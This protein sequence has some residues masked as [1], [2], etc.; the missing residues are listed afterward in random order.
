MFYQATIFFFFLKK[1]D[2]LSIKRTLEPHTQFQTVPNWILSFSFK[3]K[4]KKKNSA[5]M[6]LRGQLLGW[7]VFLRT[8]KN[9]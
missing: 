5:H 9:P 7:P 3:I 2:F 1:T 4:K 8:K 6:N